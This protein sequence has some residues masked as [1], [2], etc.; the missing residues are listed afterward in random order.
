M[1]QRQHGMVARGWGYL[2]SMSST[3]KQTWHAAND[4]ND[5]DVEIYVPIW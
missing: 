5:G 2:K 3:Y 1:L 4:T